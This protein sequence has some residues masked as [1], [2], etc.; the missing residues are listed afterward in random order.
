MLID[1]S[2]TWCG[3]CFSLISFFDDVANEWQNNENVKVMK[4]PN[5]S[6]PN[7]KQYI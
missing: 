7:L 5:F 3:P 6:K 1:M 4:V 2:A